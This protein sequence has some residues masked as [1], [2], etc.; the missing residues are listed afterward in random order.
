MILFKQ[1]A[2]CPIRCVGLILNCSIS[3]LTE[4]LKTFYLNV[5]S[6]CRKKEDTS[7]FYRRKKFIQVLN[8]MSHEDE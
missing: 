7:V 4:S 2:S 3:L 6:F 5:I 1:V 8:D